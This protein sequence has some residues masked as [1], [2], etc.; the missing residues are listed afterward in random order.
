MCEQFEL[1][2]NSYEDSVT[3]F[4]STCRKD[5]NLTKIY[6]Y[7]SDP[8]KQARTFC[9][10]LHTKSMKVEYVVKKKQDFFLSQ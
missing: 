7:E 8:L 4:S 2:I 3:E 1:Y 9:L 10:T 5:Q 6:L